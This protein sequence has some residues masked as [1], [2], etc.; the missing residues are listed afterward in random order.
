MG[1][2]MMLADAR[3]Q[4]TAQANVWYFQLLIFNV[5][6]KM[7][8][9]TRSSGKGKKETGVAVKVSETWIFVYVYCK[10]SLVIC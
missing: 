7:I 2:K 9:L 3:N 6:R 4:Q 8:V 10:G 1:T 5:A